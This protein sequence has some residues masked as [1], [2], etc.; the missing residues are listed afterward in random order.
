MV[1]D[2]F[3]NGFNLYSTLLKTALT[4]KKEAIKTSFNSDGVVQNNS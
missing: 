1:I 2:L 4:A 3:R